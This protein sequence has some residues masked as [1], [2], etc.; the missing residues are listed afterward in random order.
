MPN[1][2]GEGIISPRS[3]RDLN[4]ASF[5][6]KLAHISEKTRLAEASGLQKKRPDLDKTVIA[7]YLM[8][9]HGASHY[10][11]FGKVEAGAVPYQDRPSMLQYMSNYSPK[12]AACAKTV[13]EWCLVG[14]EKVLILVNWPQCQ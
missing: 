3:Q 14:K 13:G 2:P 1:A 8:E 10:F 11:E 5:D 12:L 7:T 4:V 9:D 6:L